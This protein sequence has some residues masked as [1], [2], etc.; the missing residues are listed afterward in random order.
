MNNPGSPSYNIQFE[1]ME[2]QDPIN[3]NFSMLVPVR[4]TVGSGVEAS[5]K[6]EIY[7]SRN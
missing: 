7:G 6:Y 4:A 1:D 5:R 2:I 3:T